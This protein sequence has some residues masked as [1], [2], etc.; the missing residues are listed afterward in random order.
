[1]SKIR[2][3]IGQS[4]GS[5][6]SVSRL[7]I[8]VFGQTFDTLS[9]N[10]NDVILAF[11]ALKSVFKL[12]TQTLYPPLSR[13]QFIPFYVLKSMFLFKIRHFI[14]H[15]HGT[16]FGISRHKWKRLS[17]F[18]CKKKNPLR[19]YFGLWEFYFW[20]MVLNFWY[21]PVISGFLLVD[22]RPL[23][24]EFQLLVVDFGLWQ[25]LLS[26]IRF[27][28]PLGVQFLLFE[29]ILVLWESILGR[30]K[31]ILDLQERCWP[32]KDNFVPLRFVFCQWES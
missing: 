21:L 31:S 28:A 26:A 1:M 13:T 2:Y 3:I 7:E 15:S 29:V 16:Q 11:R 25:S 9:A 30:F 24:I 10:R 5:D 12:K 19:V 27:Q 8:N 18:G 4:C 14:R 22:F 20:H 32:L 6:F 17:S 23:E